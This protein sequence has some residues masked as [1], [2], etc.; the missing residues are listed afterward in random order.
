M[1]RSACGLR[2]FTLIELLVVIAII[3]TLVTIL[4]P[5]LNNF[6]RDQVLKN[7]TADLRS[8][9][10]KTQNNASSGLNC[11]DAGVA[12]TKW[13]IDFT[14]GASGYTITPTCSSGSS[15]PHSEQFPSGIKIRGI[16]LGDCSLGNSQQVSVIFNNISSAIDFTTTDLGCP[17]LG[18]NKISIFLDNTN[19]VGGTTVVIEKGGT[20]Y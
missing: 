4:L 2:G 3:G 18:T 10:K 14:N 13:T 5:Q 20:V 16:N 11:N 9:I 15:P 6:N 8:N 12:A 19:A 1:N 17:I 7:A